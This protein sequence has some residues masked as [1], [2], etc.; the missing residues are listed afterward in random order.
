MVKLG[1]I[2]KDHII[3]NPVPTTKSTSGIYNLYSSSCDVFKHNEA[4]FAAGE[5]LLQGSRGTIAKATH[6]CNT[7]FSASNNVFVLSVV[8]A[9]QTLLKYVYYYL[10]TSKIT[11]DIATTSVI[12][13][14]TK[15]MFNEIKIPLPSLPIQQEIVTALDLIY[16]NAATAKAAAASVKSQ[17]AAVVRSVGVRGFERKKLGDLLEI[18]GGDYITKSSETTGEYP[19]YGGGAASYHI[20]R[21][22]REPTCVI[23]KDGMSAS[24]V[25]IV[26]TRF[27]LN[28]H[29]WTLKLNSADLVEKFLHWQLYF[30]SDE[31]FTLATGSCQKGLNQKEF[32]QF[33][34]YIPPLPIQHEVLAILNEMEA[35]LTTLEQMA[36]KAEQRAKFILDGYLTPPPVAAAP[37][38]IVTTS[39]PVVIVGKKVIVKRKI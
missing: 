39:Q 31:I 15:T 17:M 37:V 11:D 9:T 19:V 36:A 8:N 10:K 5:Y 34:I 6:Y 27:F 38:D 35:E 14:L 12:P 33:M 21:F 25:Q 22:N 1:D 18:E 26:N 7:P 13:M 2:L 20:N 23:N 3:K 16:N 28:H 24:C 30:R 4:E 29:G 32:T